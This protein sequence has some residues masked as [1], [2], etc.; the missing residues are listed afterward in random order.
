MATTDPSQSEGSLNGEIFK[1]VVVASAATAKKTFIGY[2]LCYIEPVDSMFFR[3]VK[4]TGTLTAKTDLDAMLFLFLHVNS[5]YVFQLEGI[6]MSHNS[7]TYY[8]L[9]F[10]KLL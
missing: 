1:N 5:L 8:T 7:C 10:G 3:V 9:M 6:Y 2:D 4:E